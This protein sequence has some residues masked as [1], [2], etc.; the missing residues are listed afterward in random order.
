MTKNKTKKSPFSKW[1]N[2]LQ[3]ESWQLELLISGFV[4]FALLESLAIIPKFYGPLKDILKI[5]SIGIFVITLLFATFILHASIYIFLINLIIHVLIRSL[6]IGAIGLRYVSGDI[7]YDNLNYSSRFTN[8]YKKKIGTFDKY[9]QRLENFA[10]ILF[11]FTFLLFFILSS[12]Y[13]YIIWPLTFEYIVSKLLPTLPEIYSLVPVLIFL[14]LGLLVAIDFV[15]LGFLKKI[16]NK[17]FS[18]F[19]LPIYRFFSAITLSFLWR[20]MLL[21]FLDQ[22]Y[23][24]RLFIMII[25]YL[26]F[27]GGI[28]GFNF[29]NYGHYPDFNNRE[30]TRIS[31]ILNQESFNFSFYEE[32]RNK[33]PETDG[34]GQYIESFSIPSKK[35]SGTISEIFVKAQAGD[36][37]LIEKIDSTLTPFQEE[38]ISHS[39]FAEF[40]KGGSEANE[41]AEMD[42]LREK[43][44]DTPEW[45]QKKDSLLQFFEKNYRAGYRQNLRKSKAILQNAILLRIDDQP[46]APTSVT[47][48][49]YRHPH[50]NSKGLLCYF[51]LDSLPVGRHYLE[52]AKVVGKKSTKSETIFLDTIYHTIPFIYTGK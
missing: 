49:Y 45:Q 52:V 20:P 29:I 10:S 18:V 47:C 23:T 2:K 16:K 41:D 4:I 8:Y 1:L 15:S 33:A 51:P 44:Y 40:M 12:L 36:K 43:Y 9:I 50:G 7:D 37:W 39:F 3:Q 19:Y 6:W 48:D 21:N 14:F 34:Y 25:P 17:Y 24:R 22:T 42:A 13:F 28:F 27:L 31:R 35:I 26:I 5:D 32:E 30:N 38:G 46:L 11:S